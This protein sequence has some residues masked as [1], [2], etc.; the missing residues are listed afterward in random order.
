MAVI[1]I[2]NITAKSFKCFRPQKAL[3]GGGTGGQ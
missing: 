2:T 1:A 3:L